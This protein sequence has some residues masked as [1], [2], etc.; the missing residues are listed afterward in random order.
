MKVLRFGGVKKSSS[1]Q[2][3][4]IAA[5]LFL[6]LVPTSIIIA[7]NATDNITGS[8]AGLNL[9][10]ENQTTSEKEDVMQDYEANSSDSENKAHDDPGNILNNQ[11]PKD[12]IYIKKTEKSTHENQSQDNTSDIINSAN[13]T[14]FPPNISDSQTVFDK[15]NESLIQNQ[16][17][18][19]RSSQKTENK[20]IMQS[21]GPVLDVDLIVPERANRNQEFTVTADVLNSGDEEARD[22]VVEWVLPEG[23]SIIE[24]SGSNV[25]NIPPLATCRSELRLA[26]SLSSKLGEREIDVLV[27]Y[28]D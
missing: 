19:N 26:A 10:M 4:L 13:H 5:V 25:C 8:L 6:V 3:P 23:I 17:V 1:G 9:S 2:A 21:I 24:G 27:S 11:P 15:T 20:S 18:E 16:S 12:N 14:S 28:L 22:V 7:E